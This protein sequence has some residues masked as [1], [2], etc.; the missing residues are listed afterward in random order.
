MAAVT[1]RSSCAIG[2]VSRSRKE[3]PASDLGFLLE[4][5]YVRR[6]V[7]QPVVVR[8]AI[9]LSPFRGHAQASAP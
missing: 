5:L 8:S 6:I 1:L 7:I 9:D 3:S 4:S 2:L